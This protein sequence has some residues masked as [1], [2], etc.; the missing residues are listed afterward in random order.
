MQEVNDK[1]IEYKKWEYLFD[2]AIIVTVPDSKI[3][4]EWREQAEQPRRLSG[5]GALS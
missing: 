5:K 3:V 4:F 2:A 1:L